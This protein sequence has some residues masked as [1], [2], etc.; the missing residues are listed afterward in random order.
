MGFIGATSD[1]QVWDTFRE[2]VWGDPTNPIGKG[3]RA[4]DA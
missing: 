4:G 1:L 3:P 2:Q